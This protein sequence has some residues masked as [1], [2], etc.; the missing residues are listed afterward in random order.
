MFYDSLYI[1]RRLKWSH[2]SLDLV[3]TLIH[4]C[5]H[6]FLSPFKD[7]SVP[8]LESPYLKPPTCYRRLS[9]PPD[10]ATTFYGLTKLAIST[11]LHIATFAV[12]LVALYKATRPP[13]EEPAVCHH[14]A[15]Y[16][17]IHHSLRPKI[18]HIQGEL[19][20]YWSP[21]HTPLIVTPTYESP[22]RLPQPDFHTSFFPTWC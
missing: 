16:C 17:S 11:A 20:N 9:Y 6:Y 19:D 12:A 7:P 10:T 3:N 4:R 2:S 18:T 1:R 15:L 14:C 5:L 8:L 21:S 22:P 13:P